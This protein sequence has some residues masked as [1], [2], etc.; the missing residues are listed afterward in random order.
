MFISV[1]NQIQWQIV[2]YSLNIMSAVRL[3]LRQ[4][5]PQ[6]LYYHFH[7]VVEF[8]LLGIWSY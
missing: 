4:G 8:I 7:P 1:N 2:P 3:D 6:T 5:V